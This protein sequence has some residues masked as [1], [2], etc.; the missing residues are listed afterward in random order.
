M[1]TMPTISGLQRAVE[2]PAST[3]VAQ[4]PEGPTGAAAR[5][6]SLIHAVIAAKLRQ[7]PEPDQGRYRLPLGE[8]TMAELSSFLGE[9]ELR[10]E[11]AFAYN[12]NRCDVLGENCGR[13]AY[14]HGWL[15]GAADLVVIRPDALIVDVKTGQ[16]DAPPPAANYQLAGLAMCLL[17]S[18]SYQFNSITGAIAKLGRDGEWTFS[19]HTWSLADLTNIRKRIDAARA[20]WNAAA[21]LE[22]SGWGATPKPGRHCLFARCVCPHNPKAQ[23]Q[24]VAA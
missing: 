7:W 22:D 2:C 15:N 14:R 24:E 18:M 3:A 4:L 10:A 19:Q 20:S 23:Q 13:S 8:K 5:R 1:P 9:G 11:L 6:G 17:L 21:E 16:I 12:G